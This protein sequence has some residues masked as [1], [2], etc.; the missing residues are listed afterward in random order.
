[1]VHQ[2]QRSTDGVSSLWPEINGYFLSFQEI[3]THCQ[4][5]N[6]TQ[7]TF[8]QLLAGF[9]GTTS[10]E[11]REFYRFNLHLAQMNWREIQRP[12]FK[13][14][15]QAC[16]AWTRFQYEQAYTLMRVHLKRFP[17]DVIALYILHM[18]EFCTG[19]TTRLID[20]LEQ[21]EA[22]LPRTHN[23]Y[24]FYLAIKSFVLCECQQYE[25]AL[26]AGWAS[27]EA[28]PENVY[29]IHAVVHALHE[30][31]QWGQIIEF[32][33]HRASSWMN[34]PGMKIHICWHLVIAYEQNQMPEAALETFHTLCAMKET[35]FAKQD[36]DAVG[37]LWRLHLKY[38]DHG[39]QIQWQKQWQKLATLWTGVIE[40]SVS[41]LHK[42]HAALS[43]SA[44]QQP[45]LIEKLIAE[46][47]G[48]GI[49]PQTHRTGVAI[50]RA[51]HQFTLGQ[52][53]TCLSELEQSQP[54]WHL[55]GG[56]NAQRDILRLTKAY[57]EQHVQHALNIAS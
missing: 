7:Q 14:I 41:Y 16:E 35:P 51:I 42:L 3:P 57:A 4:P 2:S 26:T 15:Y 38:T 47:D 52:Y 39:S 55:I 25:Q 24:P 40:N 29:G 5:K 17:T 27:I 49:A 6:K 23:L 31:G 32:L 28:R 33:N 54:S 19:R 11:I 34:N 1:M 22:A 53:Q 43:F 45:F 46:C 10:C 21:C 9:D 50:L 18:F 20:V 30:T 36:L 13:L 12:E 8:Y 56:S 44:T 48:F 37:F